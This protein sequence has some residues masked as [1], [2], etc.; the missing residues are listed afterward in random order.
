MGCVLPVALANCQAGPAAVILSVDRLVPASLSDLEARLLLLN[1]VS[2]LKFVDNIAVVF[3][4]A[5]ALL[6]M[7]KW[8]FSGTC[9]QRQSRDGRR[10]A[11]GRSTDGRQTAVG[12]PWDGRPTAVR[13]PADGRPT[14]VRRPSNDRPT[15]VRR[16][17]NSR[18]D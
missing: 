3:S 7:G 8:V 5:V 16:P 18:P 13:R 12:Q 2:T 14:T 11:V 10:M 1:L 4:H 6:V 15:A 17:S 9:P